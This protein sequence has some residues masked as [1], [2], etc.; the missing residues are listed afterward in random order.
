MKSIIVFTVHKAASMLLHE[1]TKWVAGVCRMQFYSINDGTFPEDELRAD[2]RA[3][4]GKEGCFCPVRY[5]ADVPHIED[6]DIILH[7]RDPRDVMT[8]AF[9]SLAYS[10]VPVPGRWNPSDAER[11]EWIRRGIDWHVLSGADGWLRRYREYC[12]HILNRSNTV[13][14][15]YEEMVADFESWLRKYIAPFPLA[16]PE[17]IIKKLV[18]R[19]RH[20]FQVDGED[21]YRH[22]RQVA[23]GD[24]KRKLKPETIA[25]L[26]EQFKDVLAALGYESLSGSAPC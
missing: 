10:H 8:S 5:H 15:T 14:V 13:F 4:L 24:H 26:D 20:N 18:R 7:L 2:A 22:K 9:F 6:Y 25:A 21:V 17:R 16:R 12:D 19:Y 3:F 11:Q 23:P 1:L